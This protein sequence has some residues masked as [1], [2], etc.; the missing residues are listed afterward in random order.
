MPAGIVG[1]FTV[2]ACFAGLILLLVFGM[3]KGSSAYTDAI[4]E[5]RSNPDVARELGHP[6]QPGWWVSGSI[7]VSGPTGTADFET[8]LRGPS[9]HAMLYVSAEKQA[10]RWQYKVLEVAVEGKSDRIDLLRANGI[11]RL[12]RATGWH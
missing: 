5:A 12:N 1:S 3:I 7:Q 6:L 11:Q 9:G 8:P 4:R 2:L 10:G